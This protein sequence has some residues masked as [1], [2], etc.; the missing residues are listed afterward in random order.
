MSDSGW[1]GFCGLATGK[2]CVVG[3]RLATLHGHIDYV[4]N[5]MYTRA[6]LP[7]RA[8]QPPLLDASTDVMVQTSP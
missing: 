8:A 2:T 1:S 5:L 3:G 6:A 4:G 7:P